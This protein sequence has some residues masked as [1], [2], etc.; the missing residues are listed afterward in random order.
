MLVYAH[1]YTINLAIYASACG[2][3][4]WVCVYARVTVA[5]IKDRKNKILM[6]G[7]SLRGFSSVLYTYIYRT[8]N[9]YKMCIYVVVFS[10][11]IKMTSSFILAT[12]KNAEKTCRMCIYID[13]IK[14]GFLCLSERHYINLVLKLSRFICLLFKYIHASSSYICCL[15]TAQYPIIK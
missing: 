13:L 12:A 2:W 9:T 4:C 3:C 1:Y 11:E 8:L 5:I 7:I 14:N 10:R 15:H 6:K